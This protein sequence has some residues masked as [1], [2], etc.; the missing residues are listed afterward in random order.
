MEGLAD[1]QAADA[2]RRCLD[3]KYVLSLDLHEP[4][5]DFTLL[6]DL[7][8]T[9]LVFLI[10]DQEPATRQL[11]EIAELGKPADQPTRTPEFIRFLVADEQ[12][13][14]EGDRLDFRDEILAQIYDK[15]D[16]DLK[17]NLIFHIEISD[18]GSTR[19]LPIY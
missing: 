5:F 15:G 10:L 4:G 9:G 18:E 8:L 11:Y 16:P 2:V 19:G 13:R 7:L 12:P 1:R 14:I 3:W 17:R 6:H